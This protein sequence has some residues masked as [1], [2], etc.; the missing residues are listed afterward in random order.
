MDSSCQ[1]SL[2][3]V[4]LV[5]GQNVL[6]ENDDTGT[7]TDPDAVA[8]SGCAACLVCREATYAMYTDG[9]KLAASLVWLFWML[10]FTVGR[11]GWAG[12]RA[13]STEERTFSS[14]MV[15]R[16]EVKTEGERN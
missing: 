6:V 10:G 12:S 1:L 14:D 8:L 16:M 13:A 4:E 2:T 7:Q 5:F 9:W 11:T 15:A 3:K